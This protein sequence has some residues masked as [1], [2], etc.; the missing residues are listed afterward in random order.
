MSTHLRIALATLL[1]TPLIGCAESEY[2]IDESGDV[3][4]VSGEVEIEE[5]PSGEKLV[6]LSLE[7]L[8]PASAHGAA[9][10]GY[11]VWLR[12]MGMETLK[13]GA[14]AYFDEERLGMMRM[15]TPYESFELLVTAEQE[16]YHVR[17]PGQLVVA[18]RIVQ[19]GR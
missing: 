3:A 11:V 4:Q 9:Y 6:T 2:T 12:P 15:V 1:A 17:E 14:L 18:R 7:E 5:H 13:A 19:R 16:P 10:D 8:P